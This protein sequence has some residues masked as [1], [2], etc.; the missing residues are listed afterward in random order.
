MANNEKKKLIKDLESGLFWQSYKYFLRLGCNADTLLGIFAY[1]YQ[2]SKEAISLVV[3]QETQK[4]INRPV[5][6]TKERTRTEQKEHRNQIL[7]FR[8]YDLYEKERL[9]L[10]DAIKQVAEE[11]F[12]SQI[13]VVEIIRGAVSSGEMKLSTSSIITRFN[14]PTRK[15]KENAILQKKIETI[16]EKVLQNE[17]GTV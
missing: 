10:D 1:Q 16:K 6:S 7:K 17:K 2:T 11:F 8:F 15:D 9:R 12:L 13:K 14:A 5:P 3:K 4:R